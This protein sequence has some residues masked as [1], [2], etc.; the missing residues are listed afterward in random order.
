MGSSGLGAGRKGEYSTHLTD[1]KNAITHSLD[2]PTV[3]FIEPI[4]LQDETR[5]GLIVTAL[6]VYIIYC[7]EF[8]HLLTLFI[9]GEESVL[10]SFCTQG[11]RS[12]EMLVTCSKA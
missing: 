7:A 6:L 5:R 8:F 1:I 4:F 2:R 12:L 11:E 10:Y 3:F 9:S